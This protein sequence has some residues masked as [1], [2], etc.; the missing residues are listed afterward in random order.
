VGWLAFYALPDEAPNAPFPLMED[1]MTTPHPRAVVSIAATIAITLA[2]GACVPGLSR[3]AFERPLPTGGGP[4]TIRFDND[5]REYAHVYLVDGQQHQWLLGHVEPW[6]RVTL[7]IPPGA[8]VGSSGFMR[9]AV[10][11]GERMT[12]HAALNPRATFTAAQPAAAIVSQRYLFAQGMLT[13][14]PLGG[15]RI[16]VGRQ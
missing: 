5:A 14:L 3:P 2:L 7:R 11:T 6:S 8:F 10:V 13:P 15:A 1:D 9:L 12:P 16:D 4:L